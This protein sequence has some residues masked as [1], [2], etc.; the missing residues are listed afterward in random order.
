MTEPVLTVLM[1]VKEY[2]PYFL[3]QAVGSL[4]RQTSPEW[5]LLVIRE[6]GE[7]EDFAYRHRELLADPRIGVIESERRRLASQLNAGMAAAETDFVAELAGDDMWSPDAVEVL[8]KYMAEHP[9][10]D[11]FH[12]SRRLVDEEGKPLG[13]RVAE[14]SVTLDDFKVRAPVKRLLCW[15]VSKAMSFGGMDESL[16][17]AS[18]ED[19]DFP[20]TMAENEAK[21]VSVPE[22]LYIYRDH[23]EFS[24]PATQ[25]PLSTHLREQRRMFRKHGL[26]REE[27]DARLDEARKTYLEQCMYRTPVDRA[28]KR[29]FRRD[30]AP[31]GLTSNR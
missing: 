15:R 31:S 7:K 13:V 1:P 6:P 8:A 9:D 17:S 29:L 10:A 28:V 22:C 18:L 12:S 20:W 21:F 5:R 4:L 23:R 3:R 26:S 2:N 16:G 24:G 19:L 14:Q 25:L 11:L 27:M 30:K